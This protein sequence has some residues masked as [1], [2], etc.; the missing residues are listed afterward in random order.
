M[1]LTNQPV[2]GAFALS[3]EP[4]ASQV[5]GVYGKLSDQYNASQIAE[6]NVGIRK[7]RKEYM[8][9]WNSTSALTGTGR[10]VE[11]V[12]APLAP[13]PAARPKMYAY[14]GMS[15]SP[16]TA[17]PIAWDGVQV[18]TVLQHWS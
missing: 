10:P 5:A 3:G 7:W 9:Y 2:H 17:L 16:D 11:A 6:V 4:M 12:I 8:D 13:F 1:P 18:H 15:I 14:Y